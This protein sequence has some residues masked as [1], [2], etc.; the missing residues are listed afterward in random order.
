MTYDKVGTLCDEPIGLT[1]SMDAA[2]RWGKAKEILP[3]PTFEDAAE[4]VK[5]EAAAAMLVAGAYPFIRRFIMDIGLK[6]KEAF[7]Q[8][9]PALVLVGLAPAKPSH[10]NVLFHHP[11]TD[12]LL[13]EVQIDFEENLHVTSNSQACVKLLAHLGLSIAITNRLCADHYRLSIYKVLRESVAMPWVV[14][15]KN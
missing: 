4:A 8:K 7:I 3:F 2:R 15:E 13:P 11:A 10:C 5:H 1:C 6:A 14:F 9:I 12:E